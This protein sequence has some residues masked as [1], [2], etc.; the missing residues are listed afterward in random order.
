LKGIILEDKR[1]RKMKKILTLFFIACSVAADSQNLASG[2]QACYPFNTNAQNYAPTGATLNGTFVNVNPTIGHTGASNTAYELNGTV[3]SYIELPDQPGL[4]SDSVFF[5]GWFRIDSLPNPLQYLVYTY[6]G[7]PSNFEAYSLH[8]QYNSLTSQQAFVVTKSDNTC[9]FSKPQVFSTVAP[10][11]GNWYHVC[12][13]ITNSVIKLWING[14]FQSSMNHSMLFSYQSGYNVFLGVTNQSNFNQPFK[15]AI[16][17]VRFYNRELTQQEITQLYTQDPACAGSPP[18]SAFLASKT[19]ICKG[20]SITF[21][22]QSTNSPTSWSW[23]FPGTPSTS[24]LS[25]PTVT[26]PNPG[27]YTVSLVASNP[28]GPGNVSVKT[29]TVNSCVS[30]E[31]SNV[32]V[33]R[34]NIYPNPAANRVYVE[35]L[36]RNT[37]VV[38]DLLG[39]PVS[40]TKHQVDENIYEVNLADVP[41]GIYFIM[42]SDPQGNYVQNVKFILV[43]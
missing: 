8:T 34:I 12:F 10:S 28:S 30:I 43:K 17:N 16:D 29:I 20:S 11:V 40:C 24:T 21:T 35:G 26:F 22:D 7:C 32:L 23:Q 1:K 41:P 25:N 2:L 6:N 5:S 39:R 27:V 14:V 3:G 4:K 13:Y 31:E 33:S 37:M 38:S 15:G 18:V 9:S 19:Q 42:I 36:G